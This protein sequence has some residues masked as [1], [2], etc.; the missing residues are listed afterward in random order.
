VHRNVGEETLTRIGEV[1]TELFKINYRF[2]YEPHFMFALMLNKAL[3]IALD[4][5]RYENAFRSLSSSELKIDFCSNDYLGFARKQ[6][7]NFEASGSTGSR[8]I[9]GHHPIYDE[10]EKQIASFH[11]TE[12]ALIFN[13]GYDA[14]LGFFSTI[15]TKGDTVIYDQLCHASI[16]DGLR[17]GLARSFS[18]KHNDLEDLKKKIEQATGNVFVVVES[19]YSMDGDK[20]SLSQIDKLCRE[21]KAY[22]VVD[23]A[24]ATGVLGLNG[25]GLCQ[26]ENVQP[27][28][29]IHTFGKALG[30]HGAAILGSQTLKDYLIN[31][32]RPFIYTTALP[33]H[34]V[35]VIKQSYD[36]LINCSEIGELKENIEFFKASFQHSS[37]I[38]SDSAIQCI[39]LG[40][41]ERAKSVAEKLQSKGMDVRPILSPTVS[42]GTER[43]RVC[44]HSFN[45]RDEITLLCN[46]LKILI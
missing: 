39:V 24:H 42:K 16:R 28:A 13:S 15:P 32:A 33:P 3:Q 2:V 38:K 40:E 25:A 37:L 27:F 22:L 34:N 17:L 29:K 36:A 31:F 19:V 18:F 35:A 23:E 43:I 9:T 14:N 10:V 11:E 21:R 8:L 46:E 26:E 5:R 7:S 41:N 12:A 45:S 30:S 20:S 6:H 1:I 44:L 4:K